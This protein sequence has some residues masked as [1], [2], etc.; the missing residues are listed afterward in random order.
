MAYLL[1]SVG[2]SVETTW[3]EVAM[4]KAKRVKNTVGGKFN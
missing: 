4:T 1:C 3:Q 2:L